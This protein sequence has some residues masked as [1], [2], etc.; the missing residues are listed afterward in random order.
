MPALKSLEGQPATVAFCPVANLLATGTMAG[1]LDASFDTASRLD[2]RFWFR[3]EGGRERGK[4]GG[5]VVRARARPSARARATTCSARPP[6]LD[7]QARA[8]SRLLREWQQQPS[9]RGQGSRARVCDRRSCF[10][11]SPSLS[12]VAP[13]PLGKTHPLP[14]ARTKTNNITPHHTTPLQHTQIYYVDMSSGE[15]QLRLAASVQAPERFNRL[16]WGAG[17]APPAGAPTN[18]LPVSWF[19]LME[20]G[21]PWP[22]P[23]ACAND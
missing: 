3:R 5:C 2:V 10:P 15:E 4:E 14:A 17:P 8:L 11:P 19:G 7:H 22:D 21:A 6:C 1:A 20:V 16:V 9:L 12:C 13:R 18:P 23:D